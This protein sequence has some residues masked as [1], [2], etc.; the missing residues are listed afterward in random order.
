[1]SETLNEEPHMYSLEY[2]REVLD[3]DVQAPEASN[4][5]PKHRFLQK[6]STRLQNIL[7]DIEIGRADIRCSSEQWASFTSEVMAKFDGYY[8]GMDWEFIHSF[9][10]IR[11]Y[12]IAHQ[13]PRID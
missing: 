7:V 8:I 11:E 12:I 3:E 2:M 9:E 5:D 10:V 1:M 13:K 4:D 6:L